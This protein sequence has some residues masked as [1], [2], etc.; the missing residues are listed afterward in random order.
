MSVALTKYQVF[1]V[2]KFLNGTLVENHCPV[3]LS[4]LTYL[5]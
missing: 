1:H 2:L 4:L 3:V 5:T